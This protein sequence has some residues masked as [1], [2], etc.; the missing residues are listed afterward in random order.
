MTTTA[1]DADLEMAS[2]QAIENTVGLAAI[3]RQ[4]RPST[5]G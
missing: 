3:P 4:V 1:N 2:S 5:F